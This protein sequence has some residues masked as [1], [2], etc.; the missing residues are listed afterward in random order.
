MA[1]P[2]LLSFLLL[3]AL[4]A[5]A[6]EKLSTGPCG[7][8][9]KA[10]V[11]DARAR[12]NYVFLG[13]ALSVSDSAVAVGRDSTLHLTRTVM[14]VQSIWK[15]QPR[16]AFTVTTGKPRPSCG[17]PFRP[18]GMY[19]VYADG[20]DGFDLVTSVCTRTAPYDSTSQATQAELKALGKSA[21]VPRF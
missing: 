14:R 20:R 15:G 2:A 17:Y 21:I 18:G 5:A 13:H 16:K 1:N 8:G 3:G 11:S 6:P 19:I 12:H 10:S 9:N 7:C 4:G